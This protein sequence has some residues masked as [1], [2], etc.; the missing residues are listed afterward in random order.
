MIVRCTSRD[1]VWQALS[2][3]R[4]ERPLAVR[5]RKVRYAEHDGHYGGA[6]YF[7]CVPVAD[8]MERLLS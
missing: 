8:I 2:D 6:V 5:C 1:L 4:S 7:R 3:D